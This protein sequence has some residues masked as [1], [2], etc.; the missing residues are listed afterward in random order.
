M[1]SLT[2]ACLLSRRS[3]RVIEQPVLPAR[4]ANIFC[5]LV[6]NYRKYLLTVSVWWYLRCKT[7]AGYNRN[8]KNGLVEYLNGPKLS[9][10]LMFGYSDHHSKNRQRQFFKCLI[11][12]NRRAIIQTLTVSSGDLS[13]DHQCIRKQGIHLYDN[14]WAVWYSNGNQILILENLA[15]N[16]F[17]TIWISN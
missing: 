15:S 11:I 6:N 14:G 5:I 12:I 16:L 7:P 3:T 2:W 17:S 8:L 13:T 1:K 4:P 9:I 10:S